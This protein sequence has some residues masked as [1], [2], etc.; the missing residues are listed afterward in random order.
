VALKVYG[1]ITFDHC[2]GL[3]RLTVGESEGVSSDESYT[4]L[5]LLREHH[6]T[7]TEVAA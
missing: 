6:T 5:G 2:A 1:G 7:M 3:V 4:L